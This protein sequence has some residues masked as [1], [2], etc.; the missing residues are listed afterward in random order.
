MVI[1]NNVIIDYEATP[2]TGA[3]YSKFTKVHC[4]LLYVLSI[5][6]RLLIPLANHAILLYLTIAKKYDASINTN[7]EG[8]IVNKM[9]LD[10]S[11]YTIYLVNNYF[12]EK[13]N[14]PINILQKLNESIINNAESTF[15]SNHLLFN[16]LLIFGK[17]PI[18][19]IEK[20]L[21]SLTASAFPKY[22]F[23]SNI[24]HL[25]IAFVN[26]IKDNEKNFK[27]KYP[28]QEI[29]ETER[30]S[31]GLSKLDKLEIDTMKEN[32]SKLILVKVNIAK[33][34]EYLIKE[35][36]AVSKEE[37]QYYIN[38]INIGEKIQVNMVSLW[39]AKYF[40]ST[41]MLKYVKIDQ[42]ATLIAIMM[43]MMK[44]KGFIILQYLMCGKVIRLNPKKNVTAKMLNKIQPR[45]DR[46]IETKYTRTSQ[47]V[48][49]SGI[50]LDLLNFTLFADMEL[51]SY[52]NEKMRG[53]RIDVNRVSE[54]LIIEEVL[55]FINEI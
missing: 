39:F 16:K 49:K 48:E 51:I 11:K 44:R 9:L 50:I 31:D 1:Y 19:L 38:N 15:T 34:I 52:D 36:G 55:R 18:G 23:D 46:I 21:D 53:V 24:I 29:N 4:D 13:Y 35:Y 7:T 26:N 40:S 30:D 45:I 54:D 22:I 42:Y 28:S 32:E 41:N 3:E 37:I 20:M 12:S 43:R 25:N 17:T 33:T 8:K 6:S 47:T 14:T 2:Y 5:I 27:S 10:I